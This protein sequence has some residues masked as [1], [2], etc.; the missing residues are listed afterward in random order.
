MITLGVK[1]AEQSFVLTNT[2][3]LRDSS[4]PHHE[5]LGST[6][7]HAGVCVLALL[8]ASFMAATIPRTLSIEAAW[9]LGKLSLSW[10]SVSD[11]S[12]RKQID[13]PTGSGAH[14]TNASL[15]AFVGAVRKER[16]KAAVS[17]GSL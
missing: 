11:L 9:P 12:T 15:A 13:E 17:A 1:P 4:R 7:K 16:N 6:C 2:E 5:I 8:E 3:R 10:S 14:L